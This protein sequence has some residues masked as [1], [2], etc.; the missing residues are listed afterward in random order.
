[1][2]EKL[3]GL[4]TAGHAERLSMLLLDQLAHDRQPLPARGLFLDELTEDA[5][6]RLADGMHH[7]LAI[8]PDG[9]ASLHWTCGEIALAAHEAAWLEPLT[10]G[11]TAAELGEGA[12]EFMRRLR[13]DGLLEAAV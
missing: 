13:R 12:L 8:G 4:A 9:Q 2:A 11:A 3:R 7:H 10:D 5:P 6:M 1:M